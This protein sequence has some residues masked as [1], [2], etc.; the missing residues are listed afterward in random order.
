MSRQLASARWEGPS[1]GVVSLHADWPE[2]LTPPI[3]LSPPARMVSLERAHPAAWAL[4]SGHWISGGTVH[5]FLWKALCPDAVAPTVAGDF[6]GWGAE[7]PA[8]WTM[9]PVCLQGSDGFQL[10]VPLGSVLGGASSS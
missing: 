3:S 6:N 1:V 2:G 7:D 8:R 10:D 4:R 5:F 9:N